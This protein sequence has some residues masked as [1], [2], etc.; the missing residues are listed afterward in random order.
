MASLFLPC[1]SNLSA[2]GGLGPRLSISRS[3]VATFSF[4]GAR[5]KVQHVDH[6]SHMRMLAGPESVDSYTLSCYMFANTT[7]VVVHQSRS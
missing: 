4:L 1:P 7:Y 2:A 3:A 6:P 5:N